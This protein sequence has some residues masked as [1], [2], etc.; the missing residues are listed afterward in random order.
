[1]SRFPGSD[2]LNTE[3]RKKKSNAGSAG[4]SQLKD[5]DFV[6]LPANINKGEADQYFKAICKDALQTYRSSK[7]AIHNL[8]NSLLVRQVIACLISDNLPD[9]AIGDMDVEDCRNR[10]PGFFSFTSQNR[11]P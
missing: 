11:L 1:M 2:H 3:L 8:T 6:G 9:E 4:R 7:V 5:G 10:A